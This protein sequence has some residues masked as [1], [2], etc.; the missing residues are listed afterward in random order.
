MVRNAK[1]LSDHIDSFRCLNK[2]K[3]F[4]VMALNIRSLLPKIDILRLELYDV[5][6]DALVLNETWLKPRIDTGLITIDGYQC[7]RAD[8]TLCNENGDPK[9]GGGVCIYFKNNFVGTVIPD[10]TR[11]DSD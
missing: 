8:R 3:G 4:K 11:C 9:P 7:L 6:F 10:V 1:N 5:K 2:F